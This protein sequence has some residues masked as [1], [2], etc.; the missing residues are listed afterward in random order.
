MKHNGNIIINDKADAKKYQEVTEVTGY[1][2]INAEGA[3]LPQLATAGSVDINAEGASL[4]QLATAGSVYIHAEG[5]SLPQLKWR[6]GKRS[7]YLKEG[8]VQIGCQ[9]HTIE[10][11]RKNG[12]TLGKKEGYSAEEI[13][14]DRVLFEDLVKGEE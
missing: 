12:E 1:M 8:K 2:Y 6:K 11:W 4:P 9:V 5:V 10:W 7:M 13:A 14:N 3:S